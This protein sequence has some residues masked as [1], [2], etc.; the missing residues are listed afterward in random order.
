MTLAEEINRMI[1]T[2]VT[3][4]KITSANPNHV[5]TLHD[6]NIMKF[7]TPDLEQVIK[8]QVGEESLD[9]VSKSKGQS[10]KADIALLKQ[11]NVGQIHQMSSKQFANIR[12]IATNP[13][14]FVMGS[15]LKKGVKG[16]GVAMIALLAVEVAKFLAL[17][18]FKPGRI[19]DI[20]FRQTIDK[21]ILVFM[22]RREQEELRQGFAE[23]IT[24]TVGGL[25]GN[26]LA[27][28]ISGNFYNSNRIPNDFLDSRRVVPN[29]SH[30]QNAQ[31]RSFNQVGQG[32]NRSNRGNP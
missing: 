20:R 6:E 11:G 22:E 23:V 9:P 5:N 18:L 24:T 10:M 15:I 4:L 21:Q 31:T 27:G 12:S 1:E 26:N 19:F 16:A 30:S 17:E 7:S 13:A 3:N 32:G 28:N 29:N 25:R 2:V 14:G 8:D